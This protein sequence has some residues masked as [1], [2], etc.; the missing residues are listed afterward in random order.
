MIRN[1]LPERDNCPY[2]DVRGCSPE[3]FGEE[4]ASSDADVRDRGE[5]HR[6]HAPLTHWDGKKDKGVEDKHSA[7]AHVHSGSAAGTCG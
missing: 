7:W 6:A 2:W 3:P 1:Y 4:E 5:G